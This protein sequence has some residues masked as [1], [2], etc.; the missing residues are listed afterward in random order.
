MSHTGRRKSILTNQNSAKG[1]GGLDQH[2]P[3]ARSWHQTLIRL[4]IDRF[5][6][7]LLII[8]APAFNCSPQV[9]YSHKHNSTAKRF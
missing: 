6:S 7:Q 1:T 9:L 4:F 5:S 2:E 8:Y 3:R